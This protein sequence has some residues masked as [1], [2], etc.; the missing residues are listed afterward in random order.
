[1]SQTAGHPGFFSK[2]DQL[3]ALWLR[4]LIAQGE[5]KNLL[6]TLNFTCPSNPRAVRQE[7]CLNKQS[8]VIA[9]KQIVGSLFK[10][11]LDSKKEKAET[12]RR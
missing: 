2:R 10:R 5:K 1:M 3:T 7:Q 11:K 9:S 6:L 4:N 8:D 12:D